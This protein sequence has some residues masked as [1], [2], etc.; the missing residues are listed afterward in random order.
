MNNGTKKDYHTPSF[1][2]HLELIN[3]LTKLQLHFLWRWL[4]KHPEEDF[5]SALYNRIDLCRKTDPNPKHYDVADMDATRPEWIRIKNELKSLYSK[6][7]HNENAD[8]FERE[9]FDIVK[10]TLAGFADASYGKHGKFDDYQCGSLKYDPPC[11]DKPKTVAFHIGNA[12]APKSIFTDSYYLQNCFRCLMDKAENEYGANSISTTTWLNSLPKW[13]EYFP[14]EWHRNLGEE[15]RDVKWHFGFWGQFISK[16]E[17]F[18]KKY[19]AILRETGELP[20]Y[21]R[22]S[23]CSFTAMRNQLD[24]KQ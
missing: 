8:I 2:D 1:K 4:R 18:N 9:G 5:D 10:N 6:T 16:K 20:F 19:A 13:L 11:E 3:E 21:P 24:T 15:N 14:E 17:T 12:V 22:N 7:E 23:H